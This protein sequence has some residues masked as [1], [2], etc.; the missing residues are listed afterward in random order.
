MRVARVAAAHAACSG[1]R[2][3]V[4][5]GFRRCPSAQGRGASCGG[6]RAGSTARWRARHGR[7]PPGLVRQ[8]AASCFGTE[9][10]RVRP[11]AEALTSHGGG[12][13]CC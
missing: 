10:P 5:A 11:A 9:R 6:A 13:I 4:T 8:G 3:Q 7:A 1:A 2:L 12:P